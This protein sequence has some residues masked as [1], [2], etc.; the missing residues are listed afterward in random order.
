MRL[1][2]S[3]VVWDHTTFLPAIH[4]HLPRIPFSIPWFSIV[5]RS[6]IFSVR[7]LPGLAIKHDH[8]SCDLRWGLLIDGLYLLS[9][10]QHLRSTPFRSTIVICFAIRV[11]E[12]STLKPYLLHSDR[13]P[14]THPPQINIANHF[15]ISD[16]GNL[17]SEISPYPNGFYPKLAIHWHVSPKYWRLWF[18]RVFGL[19]KYQLSTFSFFQSAQIA[20][21]RPSGSN[22]PDSIWTLG[23][24]NIKSQLK[25]TKFCSKIVICRHASFWIWRFRFTSDF[26]FLE[27][28][29]S[30][31]T[32]KWNF[33]KVS[34]L[35]TR[36]SWWPMVRIL[37]NYFTSSLSTRF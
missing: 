26:G 20:A 3:K 25:P 28:Q 17:K 9:L 23:F 8:W 4:I 18:F 11:S 27:F 36:I 10:N 6:Q 1:Q 29:L 35:L 31:K 21:T 37:F 33:P 7:A 5:S 15:R 19:Q 32:L 30:T 12:F 34:D 13:S 16:F 22:V 14:A 24:R 2:R